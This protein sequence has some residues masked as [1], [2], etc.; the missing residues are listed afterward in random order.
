MT[1]LTIA[2]SDQAQSYINKQ[3]AEGSYAT[4]DEFIISLILAEEKRQ[5]QCKLNTMIRE[6]LQS[7]EPIAI[8]DEWWEKK[9]GQLLQAT[10]KATP[11]EP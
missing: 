7:G 3:V 4:V 11:I 5:D 6:G 9:R 2:L 10:P 1:Q 8:T